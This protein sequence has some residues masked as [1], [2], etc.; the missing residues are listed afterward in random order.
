[1][2]FSILPSLRGENREKPG[3]G[4]ASLRGE[5]NDAAISNNDAELA[6]S[7]CWKQTSSQYDAIVMFRPLIRDD[8]VLTF[9]LLLETLRNYLKIGD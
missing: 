5:V 7:V 3:G 4:P 2:E 6:S 8:A 9:C 1:M